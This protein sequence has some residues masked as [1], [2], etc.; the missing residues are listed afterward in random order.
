[1]NLKDTIAEASQAAYQA[2]AD[3]IVGLAAGQWVAVSAD[4][5]GGLAQIDRAPRFLVRGDGL[6]MCP[7]DV[8]TEMDRAE[9]D[10]DQDW[11]SETTIYSVAG[12]RIL[13]NPTDVE[14]L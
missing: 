11:Q 12:D 9:I 5:D 6:A 14:I 1:M 7:A 8:M 10:G 13:V 2:D 3:M 4:D